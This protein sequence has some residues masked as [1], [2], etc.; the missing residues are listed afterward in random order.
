MIDDKVTLVTTL[1]IDFML[2]TVS[3]RCQH[4][5]YVGDFFHCSESVTNTPIDNLQLK[6][7]A[8]TNGLQHPLTT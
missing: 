4:K 2:I 5:H 6:L 8:N 3:R 7:I 1:Y